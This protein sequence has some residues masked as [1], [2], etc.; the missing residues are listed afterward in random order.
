VWFVR[1]LVLLS[2]LLCAAVP[3][4]ADYASSRLWFTALAEDQRV[5][6][7]FSLM[8]TDDYAALADGVFG[9]RTYTALA[10][11]QRRKGYRATGVLSERQLAQLVGETAQMMEALGIESEDDDRTGVSFLMPRKMLRFVGRTE[12]G[13][14]WISDDG[15]VE[16][17]TL[18]VPL[19][20][21]SYVDLYERLATE[22]PTR[23]VTYTTFKDW[24]FIVSG[25]NRGRKFYLR[26][27]RG[28][29]ATSGFSLS[30]SPRRDQILKR[31]AVV[32]SNSLVVEEPRV[33]AA[34]RPGFSSPEPSHGPSSDRTPAPAR[35]TPAAPAPAV[36]WSTG[37]GSVQPSPS[38]PVRSSGS[39]FFISFDGHVATNH[40]V[41]D[42]CR[43]VGVVGYG[44]AHL[45]GVDETRDLAVLKVREATISRP[46]VFARAEPRLGQ[47][48]VVLG[49]PLGTLM[50]DALTVTGGNIAS[51]SGIGG[52]A[53]DLQ[54]TAPVQPGNSGGPLLDRRGAL[55][56]VVTSRL[57]DAVTYEM[58]GALPQNVNFAVR[59]GHLTA[60]MRSLDLEP[61]HV[62]DHEIP[63]R[64]LADVADIG[65]RST[66]Q[67]TCH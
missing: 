13:K 61:L 55:L 22:K 42:D 31:I 7:Q 6:L 63:E 15:S 25:E 47:D 66:V 59:S 39:G 5:L 48:V 12:R 60:L 57:D 38:S 43:S 4:R 46:V 27:H 50:G 40:H 45:L 2:A 11:F 8:L 53:H 21:T 65:K 56:G 18:S 37:G 19:R 9:R 29:L 51:L 52:D 49:F 23:Q 10:D 36:P 16:L 44:P 58:S 26:V 1:T 41:V 30:W 67:V 34:P 35:V 20:E 28:P 17:E 3:G 33:A 64:S 24:F 54:V 14:R 32:M 62:P